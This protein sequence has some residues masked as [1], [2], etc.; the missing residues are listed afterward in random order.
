MYVCIYIYIYGPTYESKYWGIKMYKEIY[1]EFQSPDILSVMTVQRL[2]R[3][4]GPV[5][6]IDV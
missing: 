5:V 4:L 2:E 3:L 1:N 6:R